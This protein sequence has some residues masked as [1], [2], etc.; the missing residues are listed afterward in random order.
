VREGP[1][2]AWHAGIGLVSCRSLELPGPRP[3][4]LGRLL[5]LVGERSD[6]E[7]LWET[8]ERGGESGRA[9]ATASCARPWRAGPP[10]TGTGFKWGAGRRPRRE[11]ELEYWRELLD[12]R[13]RGRR[14][15]GR[16]VFRYSRPRRE[17]RLHDAL[18]EPAFLPSLHHL[19][20]DC[21]TRAAW[22]AWAFGFELGE[23]GAGGGEGGANEG[24]VSA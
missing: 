16:T 23:D 7:L 22:I 24:T 20:D 15:G 6:I 12:S 2:L 9:S 11:G 18:R 5:H 4:L 13:P 17:R 21:A 3:C 14:R 10:S 1:W 19:V 8:G